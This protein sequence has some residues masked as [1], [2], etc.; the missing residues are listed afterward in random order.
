MSRRR[1]SVLIFALLLTVLTTL[2]GLSLI[3]M[4][5][6]HYSASQLALRASQARFLAHAG[7]HDAIAKLSKDPFF[8]SGLGDDQTYFTYKESL[9]DSSGRILGYYEVAVDQGPREKSGIVTIQS[10]GQTALRGETGSRHATYAELDI[11]PA[12]FGII[13]WKEGRP[14]H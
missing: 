2:I 12:S 4:R 11:R 7:V 6:A 8:P 14:P 5:K 9:T 1:G 10:V 13:L 3:A